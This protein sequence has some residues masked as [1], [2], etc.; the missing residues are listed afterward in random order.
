MVSPHA[1]VAHG[2][3]GRLPTWH[4]NPSLSSCRRGFT[5]VELL[6]VIAIIA[7]LIALLLPAV[8]NA[9]ESARRSSCTNN[10]RQI[11]LAM[12]MFE[13]VYKF[14]PPANSTGTRAVWP[15]ANPREH[16]MFGII[17]P[18][19]EEGAVL[20]N[21]GYDFN[22]NWDHSVNRPAAKTPV[23]V[24]MCPS[25]PNPRF[26]TAALYPNN[27]LRTWEP[28]CGDYA[29]I[30]YVETS[31]YTAMGRT[32]P[33][34]PGSTVTQDLVGGM[35]QTN[36]LMRAS[37][38]TDGLSNTLAIA[39]RAGGPMRMFGRRAMRPRASDAANNC[40]TH[41]NTGTAAWADRNFTY[42]IHGASPTTFAPN[43]SC[44]HEEGSPASGLTSGGTCVINCT[45]W[46][47]I[48]AFH[49]GGANGLFGDGSVRFL[50]ESI[51]PMTLV[52]LVTRMGGEVIGNGL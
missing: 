49:S 44:Y 10:V 51:D 22:Q 7:V 36:R 6:V 23:K 18:Y 48:Y 45:N 28:A 34:S 41:N 33:G 15:P 5:L 19:I 42:S 24:Y 3:E 13:G 2:I 32:A 31:I 4:V 27:S 14:F 35:L 43:T 17:L 47:E 11:G 39:E 37:M 52:S 16:G 40:N 29:A 46:D 21:L 30:T 25:A 38:I 50:S 1:K 8:Q 20:N 12:H 9:R 26:I